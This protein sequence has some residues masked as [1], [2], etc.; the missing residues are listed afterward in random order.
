MNRR[1]PLG[2]LVAAAAFCSLPYLLRT[3]GPTLSQPLAQYAALLFLGLAVT[4]YRFC[5]RFPGRLGFV[6]AYAIGLLAVLLS[7]LS[8]LGIPF[9]DAIF[10]VTALLSFLAFLT[11]AVVAI[12]RLSTRRRV[13]SDLTDRA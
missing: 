13:A 6:P 1:A 9:I 4:A 11:L 10:V 8:W 12:A 3:I 5:V 7:S 2:F